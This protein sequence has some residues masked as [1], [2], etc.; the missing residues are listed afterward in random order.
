MREKN[1][2]AISKFFN[3]ISK[4]KSF[5]DGNMALDNN[6]QILRRIDNLIE[7]IIE[8]VIE[9]AKEGMLS[10]HSFLFTA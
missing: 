8:E 7:E 10:E 2:T 1:K 9:S 3:I 5:T 6:N 4:A